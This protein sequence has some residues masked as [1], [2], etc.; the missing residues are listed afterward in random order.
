VLIPTYRRPFGLARLLGA[1]DDLELPDDIAD[2]RVFVVDN[3]AAAS[4]REVCGTLAGRVSYALDYSVEKRR[5][6]PQARNAL[7][8]AAF[9]A[10]DF[11]C[12][13]DDD[14]VPETAW[15]VELLRTQRAHAADAVTGPCL[16]AFDTPPPRWVSDAGLF[17][18]PRFIS[19]TLLDTGYTG[20]ALFRV[21]AL[22]RMP[23]LFDEQLA[24]SGGEDSEF[25]RRFARAGHRIV[26]CD[27]AV[28][29]DSVP[30][31]CLNLRWILARSL[32]AGGTESYLE[33]KFE[34]GLYTSSKIAVHGVYCLVKGLGM[35]VV[36]ALRGRAAA[37]RA[38]HLASFGAGR[39][40]GLLGFHH[41]EY[42]QTHG[43]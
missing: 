20:N 24:L 11:V 42:R 16:S 41:A 14:E 39:V 4:A 5:G 36:S 6:I 23:A 21:A 29:H 26:W 9:E 43:H 18:R 30:E 28:V 35:L 22:L 1:L 37:V 17:E 40:G 3:D 2:L 33:R 12:F 34:P 7:L 8:A 15:L 25:F 27:D 19:G 38:L 32:R 13:L 10:A 31:T